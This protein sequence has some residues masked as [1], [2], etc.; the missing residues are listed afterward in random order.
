MHFLILAKPWPHTRKNDV[1]NGTMCGLTQPVYAVFFLFRFAHHSFLASDSRWR[2]SALILGRPL[3]LR[4]AR[5]VVELG[6]GSR[7]MP[8]SA[9]IARSRRSRSAF[10]S[11]K[12]VSIGNDASL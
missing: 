5:T 2:A 10:S 11:F 6:L 1:Q 9:A 12:I 7:P 8:S 3:F 4:L